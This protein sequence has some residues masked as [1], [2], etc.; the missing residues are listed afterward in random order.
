MRHYRR[1][2][3][4]DRRR[5]LRGL[6]AELGLPGPG[7]QLAVL[8]LG[9]GADLGLGSRGH[10]RAGGAGGGAAADQA[11]TQRELP[12]GPPAAAAGRPQHRG[13]VT[14]MCCKYVV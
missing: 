8:G 2:L 6:R 9:R 4:A 14:G 11:Q 5:H 1:L 3:P 10:G 7:L 13:V 12:A